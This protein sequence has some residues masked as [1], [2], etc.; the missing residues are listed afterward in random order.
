MHQEDIP[1]NF[2]VSRNGPLKLLASEVQKRG[3]RKHTDILKSAQNV[4]IRSSRYVSDEIIEEIA[5]M[6]GV[7]LQRAPVMHS[8]SSTRQRMQ[9]QPKDREDAID[10]EV[11]ATLKAE[12]YISFCLVPNINSPLRNLTDAEDRI[13]KLESVLTEL[14][15]D[16]DINSIL[17][18]PLDALQKPRQ[19]ENKTQKIKEDPSSPEPFN[20]RESLSPAPEET[21]P[22]QPDGFD[23]AEETSLNVL[24]DGMAALSIKPEGIGYLGKGLNIIITCISRLTTYLGATSSVMPLRA[25]FTGGLGVSSPQGLQGGSPSGDISITPSQN[26]RPAA[27]LS[28]FSEYSF[29]DAYF[30]YYHTAYPFLHEA[31]F[32]AQYAGHAPRPNITIWK[33]LL[34]TVLALGAWS[35]GD[36]NSTMDDT[37]Y[38]E[39]TRL[40]QDI[41]VFE[42][43]NLALV[44]ALLLLSNYTQKRNKPNTGWNYLG[45]AV[46]MALSLGLH[47]EFPEWKISLLQR[48]VRRR[49]WW[50]IYIFDSGASITF[51]RPVLLPDDGVMDANQVLN[52]HEE[53]WNM[54]SQV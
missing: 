41:S 16:V 10:Q 38:H 1:L 22:Q 47:K 11:C 53:V 44:Q 23:W 4:E 32:R 6:R 33:I 43:G 18:S 15:P 52:I 3:T 51:G 54:F 29:I 14:L 31:T 27:P 24:S 9:V 26:Y 20:Q 37:F 49:V 39:V 25:L 48:E 5:L 17:D 34:N 8:L 13:R 30:H 19:N 40:S 7:V 28:G 42:V 36:E 50:G 21:L 46:R 45:L 2:A 35:I 12:F